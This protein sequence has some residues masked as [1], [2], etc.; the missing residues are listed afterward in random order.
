MKVIFISFFFIVIFSF[1]FLSC[2]EEAV[3]ICQNSFEDPRDGTI[4]CIKE[5][6]NQ[7]WFAENLAFVTDSSYLNPLNPED[8]QSPFGRL[9]TFEDAQIACP[10]GW[11][12]PSDAEWKI[13]E[14]FIGINS[15][16]IDD[17][18]ERGTDQGN[19][20]KS[21]AYWVNGLD[22]LANR[23]FYGFNAFPAGEW[24]PSYGPYFGLYERTSFWTSTVYDS[25]TAGII[26]RLDENTNTVIRTYYSKK[27][28][29]SCR[30][31]QD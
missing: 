21:D 31:I 12:L 7:T 28:G 3:K 11:H 5:I 20:L 26:R 25:S 24:N 9:Y 22:T 6:G 4:Y 16:V 27:M 18:N 30:C 8:I 19:T 10:D 13:L 14:N 29:F 23:N 15:L 17:L 1:C 2:T